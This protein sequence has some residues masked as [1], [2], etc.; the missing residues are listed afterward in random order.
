MCWIS[1]HPAPAYGKN[2]IRPSPKNPT[3]ENQGKLN[4]R[5]AAKKLAMKICG[6]FI[7]HED[8]FVTLTHPPG[9]NEI[10][11][12]KAIKKFLRLMRGRCRKGNE[13]KELKYILVTE[14]Q[15]YWHHHLILEDTPLDTIRELWKKATEGMRRGEENR[16]SISTLDPF[17][18]FNSLAGY[19]VCPEKPSRRENPSAEESENAKAPRKKGAQRYSCSKNLEKPTVTPQV[20]KRVSKSEPRPPKGYRILSWN[21]WCDNY[22]DMH[23]EYTCAWVGAGKPKKARRRG[24]PAPHPRK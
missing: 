18:N 23:A 2:R 24:W 19:L 4:D 12:K 22:G 1:E 16:V 5:N 3:A 11:A 10:N 8:L 6:N 13:K 14:K 9:V 17:D 7:P 20:I 15:G 21:K